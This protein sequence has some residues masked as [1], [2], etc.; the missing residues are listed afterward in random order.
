MHDR[1]DQSQ[2][3]QSHP[4]FL[5]VNTF[6]KEMVDVSIDVYVLLL[7][8]VMKEQCLRLGESCQIPHWEEVED[9]NVCPGSHNKRE[10]TSE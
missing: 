7:E 1:H 4:G 2:E 10:V 3:W 6:C 5:L 8:Q 9:H